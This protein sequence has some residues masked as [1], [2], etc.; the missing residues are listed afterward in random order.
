MSSAT[1]SV[2]Q[3]TFHGGFVLRTKEKKVTL[4]HNNNLYLREKLY[5][6]TTNIIFALLCAKCTPTWVTTFMS[7][8]E[9]KV[10]LAM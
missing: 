7:H 4:F 9:H 8:K 5:E 6:E 1:L 2:W 10:F 3:K